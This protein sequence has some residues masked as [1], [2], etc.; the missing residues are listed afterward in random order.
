MST[1]GNFLFDYNYVPEGFMGGPLA[2]D[3]TAIPI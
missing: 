1:V 3:T 2:T